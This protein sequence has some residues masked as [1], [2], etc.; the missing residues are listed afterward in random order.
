MNVVRINEV[1][2]MYTLKCTK[3]KLQKKITKKKY[4]INGS[5]KIFEEKFF[6]KL[7]L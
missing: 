7:K 5:K 1:S 6:I 2:S 3:K 4:I